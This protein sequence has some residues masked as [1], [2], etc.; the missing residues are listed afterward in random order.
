MLVY[1]KGG[2]YIIVRLVASLCAQ[3]HC[4][5]TFQCSVTLC[6]LVCGTSCCVSVRNVTMCHCGAMSHCVS[7]AQCHIVSMWRNVTTCHCGA[8]WYCAAVCATSLCVSVS[9]TWPCVT[10]CATSYCVTVYASHCHCVHVT[11]RHSVR[12]LAMCH[13]V[14]NVTWHFVRNVT[15][16]H[17]VQ[18]N[19]LSPCAQRDIVPLCVCVCVCTT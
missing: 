18:C 15:L 6:H 14:C 16:C 5:V 19:I 9:P 10:V 3:R 2:I 17:C 1:S 7:V 8:T 4:V 12:N 11:L 13:C